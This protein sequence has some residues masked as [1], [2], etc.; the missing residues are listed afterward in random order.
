MTT[1]S[2]PQF[3]DSVDLRYFIEP[4]NAPTD[5]VNVL[6][7]F[8]D[9]LY[10]KT[11]DSHFVR[12]MTTLLG[13][14]GIGWLAFNLTTARLQLEATGLQQSD[15]ES[16]YG[17]PFSFG[18]ILTETFDEDTAG[19]L[20]LNVWQ[21]IVAQDQ[22]Y[23]SRAIQFLHAVRLGTSPM[24]MQLAA[25]SGI[26][27]NVE[28][29]ENY[30]YLYDSH[31][32]DRLGLRSY[33]S[34]AALGEFIVVPRAA[35]SR[36]QQ[37]S[38]AF[39]Q[40][41]LGTTLYTISYNGSAATLDPT[42]TSS[43]GAGQ[44]A[45]DI[46]VALWGLP[47]IG[48]GNVAVT[49][50]PVPSDVIVT[51]TGLLANQDLP[52]LTVSFVDPSTGLTISIP[53]EI[54]TGAID[55]S[56][57]TVAIGDADRHAM[58]VALDKLRPVASYPTFNL[59]TSTLSPQVWSSVTASSE[60]YSVVRYV[61][62]SPSVAWPTVD[63]DHW[64]VAAQETEAPQLSADL[65][66]HYVNFHDVLSMTPYTDIALTDPEYNAD[67]AILNNYS[68]VHVGPFPELKTVMPFFNRYST[69][70]GLV[71][72][73]DRALAAYTEPL[74]V[75]GLSADGAP[76]I[77]G[78]Y[79]ADYTGLQGVPAL[80]YRDDAFW[81]SLEREGGAEILEIDL[82]SPQAVNFIAFETTRKP[83]TITTDYDVLDQTPARTF[84]PVV[85][86]P[87]FPDQTHLYFDPTQQNPWVPVQLYF[88][89][90][91]A[92]IFTRFIRL[93]FTRRA[94]ATTYGR[95]LFD[96]S[97]QIQT[98]WSIDVRNLRVGR[99]VAPSVA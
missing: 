68:S 74:T 16:F 67:S 98:P 82:G 78:I 49:G 87:S 42:I 91:Q 97:T 8:P 44:T 63:S 73:A 24:G 23:R 27:L 37:Q 48:A 46:Q 64:I 32:D 95:F 33:G 80:R 62:G 7:R 52:S 54:I 89:D 3:T 69:D 57:E 17:D 79:P 45:M 90:G 36:T 99:N 10:S 56:T 31:S 4:L 92:L 41:T 15:L 39:S 96:T 66:Q 59:G 2:A 94:D 22:A 28:I 88:N 81:S 43:A 1:V 93:T 58:Q 30:R 25:S 60:R 19:L 55:P 51:F 12:F 83:L 70:Y 29:V 20:P 11:P 14:V 76:F 47:T 9:S 85:P 72:S 86:D 65:S 84:A 71:F 53:V 50:G 35:V 77:N 40:V 26:G 38:L 21:T 5:P 75:T 13:P 34:S 61:T 6:T 18:R